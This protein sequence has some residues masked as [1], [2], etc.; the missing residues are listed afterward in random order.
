MLL[1]FTRA[2]VSFGGINVHRGFSSSVHC[3]HLNA[4]FTYV[5][6]SYRSSILAIGVAQTSRT[7]AILKSKKS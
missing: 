7:K 4:L 2:E 3:R 1:L 5:Q 6:Y